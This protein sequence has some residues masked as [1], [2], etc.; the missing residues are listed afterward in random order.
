MKII[1]ISIVLAL[2]ASA[3]QLTSASASQLPV[4]KSFKFTPNDVESI[5][6]DT[7]VMVEIVASHPIELRIHQF[8]F[9]LLTQ[10]TIHLVYKYL[11][12][13]RPIISRSVK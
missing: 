7:K 8:K 11:D 10:K 6:A 4:I 5:G 1:R 2:I 3:F 9:H 12:L 13:K